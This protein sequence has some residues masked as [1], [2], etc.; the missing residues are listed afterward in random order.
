MIYVH[1]RLRLTRCWDWEEG[2][3]ANNLT[4]RC[5]IPF[6]NSKQQ[7]NSYQHVRMITFDRLPQLHSPRNPRVRSISRRGARYLHFWMTPS[8][9]T[10]PTPPSRAS[11]RT[12]KGRLRQQFAPES[13]LCMCFYFDSLSITST[14]K[15]TCAQDWPE[16]TLILFLF[17]S[18]LTSRALFELE[19]WIAKCLLSNNPR[20]GPTAIP[21]R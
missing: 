20:Q 2:G 21:V 19:N 3:A 14:H 8:T 12:R 6:Q 1:C 4:D 16:E 13:Q 10:T 15:H 17:L 11:E 7:A 9:P 5:H 18:F